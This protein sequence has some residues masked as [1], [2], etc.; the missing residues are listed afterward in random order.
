MI[1]DEAWEL[2]GN[3][4]AAVTPFERLHSTIGADS[5]EEL[6]ALVSYY[7]EA[8]FVSYGM[9]LSMIEL[10]R[11]YGMQARKFGVTSATIVGE[12]QS[13]DLVHVELYKGK[14]IC[15]PHQTLMSMSPPIGLDGGAARQNQLNVFNEASMPAA[16]RRDVVEKFKPRSDND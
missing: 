8:R 4:L 15:Y 12:L 3:K 2:V 16:R 6:L 11:R 14:V 10:N 9:G 5:L 7:L 1:S 13:L